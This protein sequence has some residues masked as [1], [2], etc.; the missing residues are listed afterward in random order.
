M[1]HIGFQGRT[2]HSNR[3]LAHIETSTGLDKRL[4][5]ASR[6]VIPSPSFLAKARPTASRTWQ[7]GRLS[8]PGHL[9]TSENIT[10]PI[11]EEIKKAETCVLLMYR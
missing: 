10:V 9:P 8:L 5:T 3:R 1:V 4:H 6:K 2:A 7:S 11:L